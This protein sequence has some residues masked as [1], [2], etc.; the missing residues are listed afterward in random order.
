EISPGFG[1]DLKTGQTPSISAWI[2]G[3]NTT[4]ASTIEGY[5]TGGHIRYLTELATNAGIDA[6]ALYKVDLQS[7]YR[8]N[9]SFESI[10]SIGPKTPALLLLF[11]P[12]ILMAVSISREK[13]VGTI[14][15]FYVT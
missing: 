4:R 3:A 12:A 10:F 5:V 14:T 9:P 13:E 11:F 8:Y 6:R 7:R 1:R 2:D 15:N